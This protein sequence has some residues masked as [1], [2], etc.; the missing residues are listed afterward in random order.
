[1][2]YDF[3]WKQCDE[4]TANAM[5]SGSEAPGKVWQ[6]DPNFLPNGI[7]KGMPGL[8]EFYV[9][10]SANPLPLK[11]DFAVGG[12]FAA[13]RYENGEAIPYR[14]LFAVSGSGEER[15]VYYGGFYKKMDGRHV[16]SGSLDVNVM[17]AKQ[18]PK[19][20]RT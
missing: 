13:V 6:F 8:A 4:K 15:T 7:A 1:M 12:E 9:S 20:P 16:I 5:L 11:A 17:F 10:G 19:F 3:N 18:H 14:W 2:A